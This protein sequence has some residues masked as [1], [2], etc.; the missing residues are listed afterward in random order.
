MPVFAHNIAFIL[1]PEGH[2]A[3][4]KGKRRR[5]N[6]LAF[7]DEPLCAPILIF[8]GRFDGAALEMILPSPVYG[9]D[10]PVLLCSGVEGFVHARK[11]HRDEERFAFLDMAVAQC[12]QLR[13][14][15]GFGPFMENDR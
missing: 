5:T 13:G 10:V 14:D 2:V 11:E 1:S 7:L 9:S 8:R 15:G 6:G 3:M 4:I 12:P